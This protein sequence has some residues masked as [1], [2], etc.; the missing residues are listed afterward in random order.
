MPVLAIVTQPIV[1]TIA[2]PF[3]RALDSVLAARSVDRVVVASDDAQV[4]SFLRLPIEVIPATMGN[5]EQALRALEHLLR[6]GP[7]EA[8]ALL[9]VRADAALCPADVD[10]VVALFRRSGADTVLAVARVVDPLWRSERGAGVQIGL[11]PALFRETGELYAVKPAGFVA[12]GRCPFGTTAL[13]EV[14]TDRDGVRSS[15]RLLPPRLRAVALDFDGVFTDNKVMVF[16]DGRESVLCSRSD[17]WGLAALRDAGWPLIVISSETN[18]VVAA[19]CRKL[20]IDCVQGVPDKVATLVSWLASQGIPAKET[21]YL[22]N[23]VNDIPCLRL[24]GVPAVVADSHPKARRL[25][26]LVLANQGG[27]GA[28]RELADLILTRYG[29]PSDA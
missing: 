22:G 14:N 27:D 7:L 28:L 5:G 9:I 17:G 16:D 24:V 3:R 21:L 29:V 2:S 6:S 18:P 13:H 10:G 19:R 1:G 26:A 8:D 12:A 20:G 25:A 4:Q 11:E 23:D 15:D